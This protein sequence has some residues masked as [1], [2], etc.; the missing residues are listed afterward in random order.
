M[1]INKRPGGPYVVPVLTDDGTDAVAA[2]GRGKYTLT[3]SK[4]YVA[5]L[6]G[7]GAPVHSAQVEFDSGSV[8]TSITIEDCNADVSE[9]TNIDT[10]N[11]AWIA[12]NPLDSYVG[13]EGNAS[14]VAAVVSKT[15]GAVG[16]C[17][18]H[19]NGTGAAR[20]RL[21]IVVGA[22]GGVVRIAAHGKS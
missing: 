9:V 8:I 16:G 2:N 1:S 3:A 13:C 17:M 10:A 21:T 6:G 19:L 18:F 7:A 4:T 5:L 15:A 22:T 14:A 12:E 20:T 11:G